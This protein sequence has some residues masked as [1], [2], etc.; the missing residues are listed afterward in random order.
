MQARKIQFSAIAGLITLFALIMLSLAGFFALVPLWGQA[1]AALGVAGADLVL[2]GALVAYARSLQ[3]P[4]ETDMV[5]EVR[6]MAM[7][8]IKYEVAQAEQEL[9]ALK[10]A[11]QKIIQHPMDALLPTAI[12]PLLSAVV[13]GLRS[14]QKE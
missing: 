3:P 13:R 7:S 9:V 14:K 4:A 5:R 8:D 2:A 6:D 10:D 1:F 12:A 11:V